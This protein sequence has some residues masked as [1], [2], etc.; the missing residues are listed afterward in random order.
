MNGKTKVSIYGAS[1]FTGRELVRILSR[2]GKVEIDHLFSRTYAGQ[3]IADIH[4]SLRGV[5][6]RVFTAPSENEIP[7][8]SDIFFLALPHTKSIRYISE[9]VKKNKL[10]I[11]L[12][13]DYRFF[14]KEEYEKWYGIVHEDEENLKKAVY[15]I[16]EINRAQV[17]KS[18]LIANPGCYATAVILSLYPLLKE[19]VIAGT[20]YVDAKS[21]ISGAGKKLDQE[22]L[23]S[24]RYENI[25]PYKVNSH[26]HMGE[27][28]SFL[29]SATGEKWT[30]LVFCPHLIPIERGILSDAYTKVNQGLTEEDLRGIYRKYYGGER[31]VN[32]YP[33][34]K[35][36]STK[37]ADSTNNCN[38]GLKLQE[39]T[40]ELV[41]IS[42]IDNLVKGASGQAVQNMNLAMG[43][44]EAS[45]LV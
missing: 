31:F 22:Y 10:A 19:K 17:Q 3:D 4:P 34:G 14:K 36:P 42:S 26:R 37:E 1:G 21:G 30:S 7:D 6:S 13:A 8:S 23:F 32:I 41:V 20:V 33:E 16:P 27:I 40:G 29:S 2:H 25:T 12:S 15:G 45:G 5:V 43:F 44:D 18:S 35:F 11:D 9:I 38:I 28:T 24:K 39:E